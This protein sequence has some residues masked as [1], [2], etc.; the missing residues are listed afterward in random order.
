MEP[1]L[2]AW[3]EQELGL[4]LAELYERLVANED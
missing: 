2:R 3:I 1:V 4:S